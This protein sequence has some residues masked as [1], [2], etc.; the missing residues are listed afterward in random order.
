[1]AGPARDGLIS[2][3]EGARAGKIRVDLAHQQ[4]HPARDFLARV[5]VRFEWLAGAV[6]VTAIHLERVAEIVHHGSFAV[7]PRIRRKHLQ[8]HSRRYGRR[9][10]AERFVAIEEL[11]G[12]FHLRLDAS[13]VAGEAIHFVIPGGKNARSGREEWIDLPHHCDHLAR[14]FLFGIRI[15]RKIALLVTVRALDPQRLAEILHHKADVRVR[16]ENFQVFRRLRSRRPVSRLLRENGATNN[17][18]GN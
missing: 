7:N 8:I 16:C 13:A 12:R 10:R 17:K 15:A 2:H 14:G 11:R 6:A 9:R 5:L 18:E 1:M 4:N 3:W